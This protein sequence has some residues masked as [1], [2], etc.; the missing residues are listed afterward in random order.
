MNKKELVKALMNRMQNFGY[1]P[2]FTNVKIFIREYEKLT[3]S[4]PQKPVVP[5][6]VA[7]W[8]EHFKKTGDWDLFQAMDYCFEKNKIR[9]WLE[10]KDNQ[11]T[12]AL[13][14]I[15]GYTV[16]KEKRYTV[17]VKAVLGQYLGRYYLNN[18]ILTPQFIRT[19]RTVDEKNPTFTR[20]ELEYAGFGWV[21]DCEGIEIEEVKG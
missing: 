6:F 11:E 7:D 15:F 16:E 3:N 17:K 12:F 4:E 19:Q 20:K 10:D 14:W 1:F 5:N 21:F 9:E 13:A 18:E 8:I 2:S